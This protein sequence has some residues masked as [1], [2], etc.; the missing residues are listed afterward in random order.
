MVHGCE[1]VRQWSAAKAAMKPFTDITRDG[2]IEGAFFLDR[3]PTRDEAEIIRNYVGLRKRR[4]DSEEAL[5][6]VRSRGRPGGKGP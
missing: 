6:G 2:D 1:T 3:L 5:A 4:E